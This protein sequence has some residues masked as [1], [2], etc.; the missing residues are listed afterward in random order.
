MKY[1]WEVTVIT[2]HRTK[3]CKR[4]EIYLVEASRSIHATGKIMKL[5]RKRR[6]C[7]FQ[8]NCRTNY[9]EINKGGKFNE[10]CNM[11]SFGYRSNGERPVQQ[12]P[13]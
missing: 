2:I 9:D 11:F 10:V 8:I 1:L 6:S 13:T 5:L 12:R 7:V 4:L 3:P